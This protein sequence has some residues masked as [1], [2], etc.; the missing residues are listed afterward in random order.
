MTQHVIRNVA[1]QRALDHDLDHGMQPP[2]F[3]QY[4]EQV[5]SGELIGG[6]TEFAFVQL[7]QLYQS[8]LRVVSQIQ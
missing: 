7:A 6:D 4:R 3:A 5:Q 1:T 8:F 2:K